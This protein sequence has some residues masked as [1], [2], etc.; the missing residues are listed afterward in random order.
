MAIKVGDLVNHFTAVTAD[1]SSFD[2]NDYIGKQPLV[3]YFYP[4][5]N[6]S[7]CTAQACSFRDQY[8]DF[9]LLGAEVIGVSSD[10]I[11][12]HQKFAK[13]YRLPFILLSDSEKKLRKLFGVP[14]D[15]LGLIPG[16]VTYVLDDKGKVQLIFNSMSGPIHIKKAL[17]CIKK[18]SEKS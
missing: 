5:D 18:M 12:S 4:K 9:K 16:R 7:V 2:S 3:I 1:G 15:L 6:T 10:S 14:N 11:K 8:E 13:Q 17:A